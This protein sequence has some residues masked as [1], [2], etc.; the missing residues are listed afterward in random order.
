MKLRL[1]VVVVIAAALASPAAGSS[2]AARWFIVPGDKVNCELG[3]H[4]PG[5]HPAT[6][7]WCLAYKGGSPERTARAVRMNASAKLSFCRGA[8]CIGNSP[9]GTPTLKLGHS[10]HVGPFRC[11]ALRNGVRC[12]V[13]KLGHGFVLRLHSLK[14]V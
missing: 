5:M 10:I 8:R 14:R 7:V 11:T 4:R 2:Q 9:V 12:V 13:V 1:A 3:L 6:Y